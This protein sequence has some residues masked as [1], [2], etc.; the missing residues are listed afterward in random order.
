M[1]IIRKYAKAYPRRRREKLSISKIKTPASFQAKKKKKKILHAI[2]QKDPLTYKNK[3]L[4]VPNSK[5]KM[6][7]LT[8][9]TEKVLRRDCLCF[10]ITCYP[11]ESWSSPTGP[12]SSKAPGTVAENQLSLPLQEE[13]GPQCTLSQLWSLDSHWAANCPR[14]DSER[15]QHR[16][17][18]CA[19][20]V[21]ITGLHCDPPWKGLFARWDLDQCLGT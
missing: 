17:H 8:L 16:A 15:N 5:K 12:A 20:T 7:Q 11:W 18:D 19:E 3:T 9:Q 14:E 6:E 4:S 2:L 21:N 10:G 13:W 1:L